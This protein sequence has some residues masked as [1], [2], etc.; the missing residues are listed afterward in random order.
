MLNKARI[1][2]KPTKENPIY[3]CRLE[4]N[5]GSLN[6]AIESRP[7]LRSNNT[8]KVGII[9]DNILIIFSNISY[10]DR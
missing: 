8:E 4:M 1:V 3:P 5:K 6:I 10:S 2:D 9:I 7:E